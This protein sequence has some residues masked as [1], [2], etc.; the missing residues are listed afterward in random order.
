MAT[1]ALVVILITLVLW[2]L[3]KR[4]R[5]SSRLPPGPEGEFLFGNARQIPPSRSWI[6]YTN[7]AKQ[8]GG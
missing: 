2:I 1:L 8:F 3:P 4:G 7:L 6:Y 5:A